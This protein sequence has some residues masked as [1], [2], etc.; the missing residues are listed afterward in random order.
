MNGD[1]KVPGGHPAF[2]LFVLSCCDTLDTHDSMVPAGSGGI[3]WEHDSSTMYSGF[4]SSI[5]KVLREPSD[6][7]WERIIQ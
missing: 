6:I 1:Q 5:T 3:E 4:P 2:S 7:L